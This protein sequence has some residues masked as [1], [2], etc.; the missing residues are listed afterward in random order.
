[1]RGLRIFCFLLA[2][3]LGCS[4]KPSR[5]KAPT[6][7]PELITTKVLELFDK[8][9]DSVIDEDELKEAPS[10]AYSLKPLDKNENGKLEK[11]ELFD[12]FNLYVQM[13]TAYQQQVLQFKKKGR[14]LRGAKIE[15]VPA[16]FLEGIIEPAKGE[17]DGSGHAV[18]QSVSMPQ[19]VVRVG[20]YRVKVTSD[21]SKIDAKYNTDTTLG[22]ESAP[23]TDGLDT[24]VVFDLK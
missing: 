8:N 2:A 20:F 13:K 3:A 10:L 4:D 24:N 5:V 22:F 9:S 7:E 23:V 11:S 14:P 18:M 17:T 21:K 19:A 1:M 12:R 6:W 16:P 15:I